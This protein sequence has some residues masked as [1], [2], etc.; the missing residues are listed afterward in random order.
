MFENAWKEMDLQLLLVSS[1]KDGFFVL[2]A[3]G[4]CIVDE[5]CERSKG[6]CRLAHFGAWKSMTYKAC[7]RFKRDSEPKCH[8]TFCF[9]QDL[10][11]K[12]SPGSKEDCHAAWCSLSSELAEAPSVD[13]IWIGVQIWTNTLT[14][15]YTYQFWI[16]F[17]CTSHPFHFRLHLGIRAVGLDQ[18]FFSVGR[19]HPSAGLGTG[20]QG[21]S[22]CFLATSK[23]SLNGSGIPVFTQFALCGHTILVECP[24]GLRGAHWNGIFERGQVDTGP[25]DG[26]EGQCRV[27]FAQDSDELYL[28][29]IEDWLG[30]NKC[31]FDTLFPAH[32]FQIKWCWGALQEKL[33]W[34]RIYNFWFFSR[35]FHAISVGSWHPYLRISNGGV[36][37]ATWAHWCKVAV[38]GSTT[39]A[40]PR[41]NTPMTQWEIIDKRW[42]ILLRM[43][44]DDRK[45]LPCWITLASRLL[46]LNIRRGI[47]LALQTRTLGHIAETC[48]ATCLENFFIVFYISY[49]VL[50]RRVSRT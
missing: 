33:K 28:N 11:M 36:A 8:Q 38:K 41:L 4:A 49:N 35:T 10:Y 14:L 21:R 7:A 31:Q 29:S 19:P 37:R 24:K 9:V 13:S 47:F 15:T 32:C 39:G 43:V 34:I 44:G 48:L 17:A 27:A 30:W 42:N 16:V 23:L 6:F 26:I 18:Y 2:D 20:R 45:T 3:I 46:S 12:T 50:W 40:L 22:F 25:R 5:K 1:L